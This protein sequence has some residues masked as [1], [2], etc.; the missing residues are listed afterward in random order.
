MAA[1]VPAAARHLA[2]GSSSGSGF[3]AVLDL[4]GG[5]SAIHRA[6]SEFQ[7]AALYALVNANAWAVLPPRLDWNLYEQAERAPPLALPAPSAPP[8]RP[9]REQ[10]FLVLEPED[11]SYPES[12]EGDGDFE[13][14]D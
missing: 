12:E 10:G 1:A 5:C 9:A 11:C 8:A 4:P 14:V 2:S 13:A 6:V 7:V 3:S